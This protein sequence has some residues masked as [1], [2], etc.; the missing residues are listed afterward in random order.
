MNAQ[1]RAAEK[2]FWTAP[3]V[4]QG[5][6]GLKEGSPYRFIAESGL[7]ATSKH[8]GLQGSVDVNTWITM[9]IQRAIDNVQART[10]DG[11]AFL[12]TVGSTAPFSSSVLFVMLAMRR[13]LVAN[14]HSAPM[15]NPH[16]PEMIR[17]V[18]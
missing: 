15:K 8:V 4:R 14:A 9:S 3:S 5:A 13:K 17:A 11:L 7:E 1:A 16:A 18:F 6:A 10:Q 12:A 2:S